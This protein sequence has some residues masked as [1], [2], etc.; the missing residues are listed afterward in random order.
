M[1]GRKPLRRTAWTLLV[2]GVLISAVMLGGSAIVVSQG[3]TAGPGQAAR[4]PA[5]ADIGVFRPA[6][7]DSSGTRCTVTQVDGQTTTVWPDY[8]E[9]LTAQGEATTIMCDP[10]ATILTGGKLTI[11][12]VTR[13]AWIALPLFLA[14]LGALLFVPRFTMVW[15]SLTQPIGRWIRRPHEDGQ[16]PNGS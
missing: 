9:R 12:Q 7:T 15:A 16:R 5:G 6:Q 4:W 10:A 3:E 13:S 14:I 2:G 11:A 8:G 1:T